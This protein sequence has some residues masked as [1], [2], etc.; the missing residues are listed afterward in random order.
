MVGLG[1]EQICPPGHVPPHVPASL[2]PHVM[3]GAGAV[4]G[5]PSQVAAR[6][7][8]IFRMTSLYHDQGANAVL[9]AY[10]NDSAASVKRMPAK[11][12][13]R[14]MAQRFKR[15]LFCQ[16]ALRA[17]PPRSAETRVP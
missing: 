7:R 2:N 10:T 11:S 1:E 8:M 15:F 12:Q 3:D 13:R 16:R 6:T 17:R 14:R 4:G 5:Q 9:T